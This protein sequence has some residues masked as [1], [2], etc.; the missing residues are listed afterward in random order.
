MAKDRSRN[1]SACSITAVESF[2]AMPKKHDPALASLFAS[3]VSIWR[4]ICA[5]D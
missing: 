1:L 3:S 5:V 2:N 4:I